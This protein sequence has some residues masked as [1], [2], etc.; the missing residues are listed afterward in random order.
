MGN[1]KHLAAAFA[2]GVAATLLATSLP[3]VSASTAASAN[4]PLAAVRQAYDAITQQFAGPVD[5]KALINGAIAGM[6]E[7]TGDRFTDYFTPKQLIDFTGTLQG[8]YVGIGIVIGED[9]NGYPQVLSVMPNGPADKAGLRSQ[10]EIVFVNGESTL[11]QK[12]DAVA[13]RIKG[14]IDTTVTLGLRRPGHTGILSVKVTRGNVNP[15][16]SV[17]EKSLPDGLAVITIKQFDADTAS[18]FGQALKTALASNPKGL[19]LDLRNDPG[20]YLS[21]AVS[22][23]RDLVPAGPIVTVVDKQGQKTTFEAKGHPQLPRLAVLVNGLTASAAEILAGAIQAR[24]V[25]VLVGTGTYGKGSVQQI[26]NLSNGGALKVT[27]AH[28]FTPSGRAINHEGLV[29]NIDVPPPPAPKIPAFAAVGTRTLHQGEIGLDVLGVQQR[30]NFLGFKP[31]PE[32]G[33]YGPETEAGAAAFAASA[34]LPVPS[35]TLT[36]AF[37][38]ALN[39]ATGKKVTAD[40]AGLKTDRILAAAEHYLLSR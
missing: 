8:G 14:P 18:L 32:D 34:H 22:I 27:I 5:P 1:R 37:Q 30:L 11:G 15:S 20:G 16:P 26:V 36:K 19:I 24:D 3:R 4:D 17:A 23:A 29:P 12:L 35:G 25:G 9:K 40:L 28:D 7:A 31:G 2:A 13:A 6:A 39:A 38:S 10:D 33:I 21:Q